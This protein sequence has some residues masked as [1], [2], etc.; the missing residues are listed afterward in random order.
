MGA[1]AYVIYQYWHNQGYTLIEKL[2]GP[3]PDYA[4]IVLSIYYMYSCIV[5]RNIQEALLYVNS[6]KYLQA[7]TL[8]YVVVRT[9]MQG[10]RH[11]M[12]TAGFMF[13][14]AIFNFIDAS[15]YMNERYDI[16]DRLIREMGDDE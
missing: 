15:V 2:L 13:W 14:K 10:D 8:P 12:F 4:Q 11:D 6:V 9:F 3:V 1:S 16:Y 7:F 5:K